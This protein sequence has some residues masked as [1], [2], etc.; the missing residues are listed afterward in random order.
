MWQAKTIK[1]IVKCAREENQW[2]FMKWF[3][4]LPLLQLQASNPLIFDGK[5]SKAL[6]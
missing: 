6:I 1:R 2:C 4:N 5:S 3:I